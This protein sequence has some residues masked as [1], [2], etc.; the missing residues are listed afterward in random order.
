MSHIQAMKSTEV[1]KSQLSPRVG[2]HRKTHRKTKTHNIPSTKPEKAQ[3]EIS[4]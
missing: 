1:H 2:K 3:N 4:L